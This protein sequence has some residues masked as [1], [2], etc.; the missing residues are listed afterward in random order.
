MKSETLYINGKPTFAEGEVR[1]ITKRGCFPAELRFSSLSPV[2]SGDEVSFFSHGE[3]L[4]RGKAFTVTKKNGVYISVAYDLLKYFE[5]K[6]TH[7]YENKTAG[8][9]LRL[10]CLYN[11]LPI[12]KITDTKMKISSQI[13]DIR[14]L[15]TIMEGALTLTASSGFGEYVILDSCGKISLLRRDDIARG[16]V[17]SP[18]ITREYSVTESIDVDFCNSVRLYEPIYAGRKL[19]VYENADSIKKYGRIVYTDIITP[20]ENASIVGRSILNAYSSPEITVEC[21]TLYDLPKIRAGAV[22]SVFYRDGYAR[23]VAER[24]EHVYSGNENFLKLTLSSN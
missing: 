22:V 16:S 14:S 9:L 18:E 19:H 24:A 12:G 2:F 8:E 3:C 11:G 1:L 23:M 7:V 20:T 5:N 17:I 4:F 21:T 13:N 6:G 15:S 10:L